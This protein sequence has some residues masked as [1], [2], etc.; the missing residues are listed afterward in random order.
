V[1]AVVL[2][3]PDEFANDFDRRTVAMGEA[4]RRLPAGGVHARVVAVHAP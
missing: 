3:L 4:V 1:F 2:P